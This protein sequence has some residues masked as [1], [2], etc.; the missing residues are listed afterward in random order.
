MAKKHLH[1]SDYHDLRGDGTI[2]LYKRSDHQN[3]R[4]T[5]RIK[6]PQQSGFVVKSTKT[7]DLAKAKEFANSLFYKIEGQVVRGESIKPIKFEKLFNEWAKDRRV[8]G[9]K[10]AYTN[11]DIRAAE[12]YILPYFKGTPVNSIT[13][14]RITDFLDNRLGASPKPPSDST[15]KQEVRRLRS[16]LDLAS[17]RGYLTT[18]P[19]IKSPKTKP[20]ARPDFSATEWRKLHTLVRQRVNEV[21]G[22]AA[23][24]RDRFYLQQY[25]LILANSGLR[26]GEARDLCW[27]DVG[28][29]KAEDNTLRAA[30]SVHGKTGSRDVVCNPST[31]D[32]FKRLYEFRKAELA[33]KPD[34][35]E[36]VFCHKDG[37]RISSFKRAF[38]AL[39]EAA[40]LDTDK[41]GNQRVPYSLRHTYAS[42]R[43]EQGVSVYWL[44]ANMG[45]SVD[46][47]ERYYGKKR[48][49]SATSVS[50]ITKGNQTLTDANSNKRFSW[51]E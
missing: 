48:T 45:T 21:K 12:I 7:F 15:L 26:V 38:K 22:H 31:A 17:R 19:T 16:I 30:L 40:A 47:I 25:V 34:L 24:F 35:S 23:H 2:V 50:E 51:L 44:A 29:V 28:Q 39:V 10:L 14:S 5:A 9:R 49:R 6:V 36:F 46:M 37:R 42:M 32:Y 3:P 1:Y 11:S 27:K 4:Y 18:M 8:H 33:K 13:E 41:H 20:N 43:L